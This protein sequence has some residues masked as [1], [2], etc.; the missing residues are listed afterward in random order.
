MN[1]LG[2][3][4][5]G[6]ATRWTVLAPDG[7]IVASG[8]LPAVNGH[9]FNADSL[10]TF[11]AGAAAL[12]AAVAGLAVG[13]VVAGITGLTGDAPEAAMAQRELAAALGL[14]DTA[15]TVQD[16]LWIGYHGVFRPGE[17]HVV[18][19][20][21]GSVGLHIRADGSLVRAGGRGILIDDAGSAFAIGRAA[22]NL[23]YRRIDMAEPPGPLGEALFTAIGH[24]DWNG[25]RT[26]V[27][28]GG[29]SAVALLAMAVAQAAADDPAARAILH[30]AGTELARL[31]LALVRRVGVLPVALIGRAATLHP[32]IEAG[33][34]A[35]APALSVQVSQVDAA[36]AAARLAASCA[37]AGRSAG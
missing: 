15:V 10:A 11:R 20:G 8:D 22:L 3:D 4:A 25:V 16:D 18:Y 12:R 31:A 36:H 21:T 19:A 26:H 23:V 14:P 28:G 7:R 6:S 5:G 9:L 34:R 1:G 37:G 35:G 24:S 2:L 13:C 27:Y 33:L 32:A 29:R 30:D 17:G